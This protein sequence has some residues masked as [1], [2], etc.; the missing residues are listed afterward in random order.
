MF[1]FLNSSSW[2][3][4]HDSRLG[5]GIARE[6]LPYWGIEMI[7][8]EIKDVIRCITFECSCE[9]IASSLFVGLPIII[10][11][12]PSREPIIKNEMPSPSDL[13]GQFRDLRISQ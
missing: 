6:V 5:Y 12:R 1:V 3:T 13:F 8:V 4:I 9:S 10:C 7:L 11:L 2:L